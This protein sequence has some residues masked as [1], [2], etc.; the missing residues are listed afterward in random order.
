MR[1]AFKH[2]KIAT[3]VTNRVLYSSKNKRWNAVNNFFKKICQQS[4]K[5]GFLA[6]FL[7]VCSFYPE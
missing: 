7:Y 1:K 2:K 4:F 3:I 6:T 5:C